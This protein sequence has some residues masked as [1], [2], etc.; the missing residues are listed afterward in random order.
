MHE[1]A[2]LSSKF[3]K[4]QLLELLRIWRFQTLKVQ[5]LT[6]S[7][8]FHAMFFSSRDCQQQL[9]SSKVHFVQNQTHLLATFLFKSSGVGLRQLYICKQN[10][11]IMKN[12]IPKVPRFTKSRKFYGL[13]PLCVVL[14]E[15]FGIENFRISGFM[16]FTYSLVIYL[17]KSG[18]GC[19]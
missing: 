8:R 11:Y 3:S 12:S 18:L 9:K 10:F 4:V 13:S 5:N 17:L 16:Y 19:L 14:T 6:T 1:V 15:T 7:A 2:W